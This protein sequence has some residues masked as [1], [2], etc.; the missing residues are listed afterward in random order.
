MNLQSAE[1]LA[2]QLFSQHGLQGWQFKFDRARLRFGCCN[3]TQ[4]IISL[5]RVLTELNSPAKVKD[6]LLHEIAHALVGNRSGHGPKWR[7]KAKAIGC[8]AQRC[9]QAE[10]IILPRSTYIGRCANCGKEFPAQ[11][12]RR[13]VACRQ[14]CKALNKGKYSAKYAIEF[15]VAS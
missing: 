2:L 7:A 6:T 1:T 15:H 13:G 3:F 9:Y 12:K 4:K 14:C 8:R 11:R 10:D 5:S